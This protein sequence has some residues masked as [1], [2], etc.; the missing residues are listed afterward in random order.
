MGSDG[1]ESDAVGGS[2]GAGI[3]AGG[4]FGG[5]GGALGGGG[6]FGAMRRPLP[7]KKRWETAFEAWAR[8]GGASAGGAAAAASEAGGGDGPE[9]VEGRYPSLTKRA[10]ES[11]LVTI[12]EVR[13]ATAG[14][15]AGGGGDH[16][17]AVVV[18]RMLATGGV[19]VR[20]WR[21]VGR[22]GTGCVPSV[23]IDEGLKYTCFEVYT[24]FRFLFELLISR[25]LPRCGGWRYGKSEG[26]VCLLA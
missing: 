5:I 8:G 22:T 24:E 11:D 20:G 26:K 9:G 1:S 4:S 12:R 3:G 23:C 10:E 2:D 15:A 19:E 25:R 6:F 14:A 16:W 13:R 21:C 7:P 17:E 18:C